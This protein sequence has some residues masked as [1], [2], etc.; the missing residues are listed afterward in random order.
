[1]IYPKPK[2]YPKVLKKINGVL[3]TAM[4]GSDEHSDHLFLE[5]TIPQFFNLWI[6]LYTPLP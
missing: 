3:N 2:M 6:P 1:M 4:F 5:I